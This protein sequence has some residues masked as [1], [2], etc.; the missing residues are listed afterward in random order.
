[1]RV[2]T[3]VGSARRGC[4]GIDRLRGQGSRRAVASPAWR[5]ARAAARPALRTPNPR[6]RLCSMYMCVRD[7]AMGGNERL[8]GRRSHL[9]PARLYRCSRHAIGDANVEPTKPQ[10]GG[11][12]R[13]G[14][15][16]PAAAVAKATRLKNTTPLGV[17]AVGRIAEVP[18]GTRWPYCTGPYCT[19]PYCRGNHIAQVAILHRGQCCTGDHIVQWQIRS[20]SG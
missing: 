16:A 14:C 5:C 15:C 13:L 8:F 18:C 17:A 10:G 2:C 3:D 1:M 11:Q 12:P 4:W 20:R 7:E 9:V 6:S 19:G